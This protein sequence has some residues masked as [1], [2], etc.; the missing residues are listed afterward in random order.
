M[1]HGKDKHYWSQLRAALTAGHW[2]SPTPAKTPKGIPLSWSELLRK[3]NKHA[4]GFM[5]VAEVASQTQALSLLLDA[6][7]SENTGDYK[8]SGG[9][10]VLGSECMLPEE[11]IEEATGGLEVLKSMEAS[12][13]DVRLMMY[14]IHMT[15]L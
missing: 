15:I 2:S 11:R 5:E 4:K 8:E 12:N 9:C 3:F 14:C 6:N 7:T 1:A 10:L 13:F